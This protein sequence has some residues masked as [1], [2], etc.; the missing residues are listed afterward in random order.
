M[1]DLVDVITKYHGQYVLYKWP[2]VNDLNMKMAFREKRLDNPDVEN[3]YAT[4]D[5]KLAKMCFNNNYAK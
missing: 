2:S 1:A 3:V 4:V 5:I